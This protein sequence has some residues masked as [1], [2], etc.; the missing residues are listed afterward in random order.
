[1]P[2]L[3]VHKEHGVHLLGEAYVVGGHGPSDAK[4]IAHITNGQSA[5]DAGI[6]EAGIMIGDGH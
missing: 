4:C 2:S 3:T 6:I 5:P 1:M